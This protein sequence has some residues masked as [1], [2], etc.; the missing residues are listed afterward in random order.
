M[1]SVIE[2][3]QGLREIYYNPATEYQSA[4]RLYKKTLEEGLNVNRKAV[5]E[6]LKTQD[7]YQ[8]LTNSEA[9]RLPS[10]IR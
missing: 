5:K 2:T 8:V 10:D 4:E 3:E 9:A 6:W 7:S 1:D